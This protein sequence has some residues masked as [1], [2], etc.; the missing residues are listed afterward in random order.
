[1]T[2]VASGVAGMIGSQDVI[3]LVRDVTHGMSDTTSKVCGRCGLANSHVVNC[4]YF[5]YCNNCSICIY[6]HMIVHTYMLVAKGVVILD[7]LM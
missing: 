3:G 7:L 4:N 6:I 1:M 5:Y 2:D